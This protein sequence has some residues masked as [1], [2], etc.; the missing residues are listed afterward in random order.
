MYKNANSKIQELEKIYFELNQDM[1]KFIPYI[2]EKGYTVNDFLDFY[3]YQGFVFN[4]D[5][6]SFDIIKF[7]KEQSNLQY[8]DIFNKINASIDVNY[9]IDALNFFGVESL[10]NINISNNNISHSLYALYKKNPN[11]K[12][13]EFIIQ[14]IT[15]LSNK[16]KNLILSSLEY[17]IDFFMDEILEILIGNL[18]IQ[19]V[20]NID[21]D[22]SLYEAF[23]VKILENQRF[24]EKV[25]NNLSDLSFIFKKYYMYDIIYNDLK[26]YNIYSYY[27][28]LRLLKNFK[29][30]N[31]KNLSDVEKKSNYLSSIIEL[32][33]SVVSYDGIKQAI[34][35]SNSNIPLDVL[36]LLK[37]PMNEFNKIFNQVSKKIELLYNRED[38]LNKIENAS[39]SGNVNSSLFKNLI[40]LHKLNNK[41]LNLILENLFSKEYG[42]IV[43]ILK[44]F[45]EYMDSTNKSIE[46]IY[47]DYL[48]Q[49][50]FN[51]DKIK[52]YIE[53]RSGYS[54]EDFHLNTIIDFP[55]TQNFGQFFNLKLRQLE[56]ATE[57]HNDES[58]EKYCN[59]LFNN[60]KLDLEED[61]V[62][63]FI[64]IIKFKEN[65]QENI[66]KLIAI[67]EKFK[68]KG[69]SIDINQFVNT[70]KKYNKYI[71]QFNNYSLSP[72]GEFVLESKFLQTYVSY[73]SMFDSVNKYISEA[74]P[75]NKELFKLN[76]SFED[77]DFKV[78][79]D[80]DPLHFKIGIDTDCCQRIGGAGEESAID[81][82]INPLAGVLAL[83]KNNALLSQSYFHYV[84]KHN[85]YIL[86]NI[87][88][89]E[90]EVKKYDKNIKDEKSNWLS[91]IYKKYGELIKQKYPDINYIKIGK[92]YSKINSSLFEKDRLNSDPRSFSVEEEYSDFT[93]EDHVNLFKKENFIEPEPESDE[94]DDYDD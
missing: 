9:L 51:I 33:H 24:I 49:N 67:S 44:I 20:L 60:T 15:F 4:L 41:V 30:E 2:L 92:D 36:L 68:E 47:H 19:D 94:E 72:S 62:S 40:K 37:I 23:K 45:D 71:D 77:F 58:I 57:L 80:L 21:L 10:S 13:K 66:N 27:F 25:K 18:N 87:E 28:M 79:N 82:F 93:S 65:E 29:P 5:P 85:G 38:V 55:P 59:K 1:E 61:Y 75:K 83:Y 88:Y 11:E 32:F 86:D 56:V 35:D 46:S 12:L 7:I 90:D 34:I 48:K 43:D 84:P 16:N 78:L 17:G 22:K 63:N 31:I 64:E 69:Y 3:S 42:T 81:S 76:L 70:L 52:N 91:N 53:M 54:S 14:R 89:N 39:S 74:K 26:L 6:E 8:K 50:P 73:V